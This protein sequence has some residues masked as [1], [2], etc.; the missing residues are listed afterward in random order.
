MEAYVYQAA[1]LCADCAHAI[2]DRLGSSDAH[3][4]LDSGDYPQGPY[5][6]GGGE[7]DT[8]QHCEKCHVFL[9]NPLTPEGDD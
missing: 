5:G 4:S 9:E 3:E 6:D 2:Q 8:P 1:M 7:S